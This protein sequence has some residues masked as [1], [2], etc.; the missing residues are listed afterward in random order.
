MVDFD[1]WLEGEN[2]EIGDADDTNFNDTIAMLTKLNWIVPEQA[3]AMYR[4]PIF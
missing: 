2:D 3:D 1:Q 4:R